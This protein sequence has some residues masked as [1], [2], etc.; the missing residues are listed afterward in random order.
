MG[1]PRKQI[2]RR[3]ETV[4]PLTRRV[5]ESGGLQ[6]AAVLVPMVIRDRALGVILTRRTMTVATH[7]G[8]ISFPGGARED[9]DVDEV[10][11]ALREA[12]EEIGLD[13]GCVTVLGLLDDYA[14]GTGFLITPVLG[15]VDNAAKLEGDSDEVDEVFEIPLRAFSAPGVHD[16]VA[17]EHGGITYR[18]HRYIV[19]DRTIWGATAG[20]LH[21]LITQLS[22]TH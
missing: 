5:I 14:T 8:Q 7:K 13:P 16:I 15:V 20:I 12:R 3:L 9:Q 17:A 22:N 19:G 11:T 18:Y 6:S 4:I 21:P 10:A 2:L 1:G